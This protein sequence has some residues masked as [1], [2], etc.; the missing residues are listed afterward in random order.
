[1]RRLI[2]W[3]MMTLDGFF[4]GPASWDIGWHEAA[5]GQELEQFSMEQAKDIGTL[6]FGRV[7]YQGMA[8]Y[9]TTA[10]G[11][12]A[13][14]M[15]GVSKVVFSTTLDRADWNNSRLVRGKAEDEVAALK[16]QPGKDLYIFGSANLC[17][18]LMNRGLIDEY[19][20]G[21][22]PIVLGRGN[23]LFKPRSD[24]L[25]LTLLEARP[26]ATGCVILRYKPAG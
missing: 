18:T 3:N 15:N 20:V 9:W 4:E 6:L 8:S 26:L 13:D 5:W 16:R 14:F 17:S 21:L 1:M 23:P 19:R 2:V 25:N 7:T 24:R 22:A 10:Q 12:I 11:K